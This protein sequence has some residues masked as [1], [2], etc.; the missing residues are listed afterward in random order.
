MYYECYEKMV[1]SKIAI[2]TAEENWLDKDGVVVEEEHLAFGR[3]TKYQ[4]ICPNY[5][6]FV[7]EVGDNTSQKDD[8]NIAGTKYVVGRKSRALMRA[9]HN[10]CH[11]TTL[12][13]S[14]A[15]GR[16]ILCVI[17]VACS[18]I[19]AKIRMGLQ[20][21]C[22]V[23]GEGAVMENLEANS[24]GAEKYFPFGPTCT[25]DGK[26]IPTF[27]GCSERGGITPEILRE[28]MAHIDSFNLFDREEATPVLLLDGHGSR[29]DQ[30]FLDYVN[31]PAT[32]WCVLIGVPYG[33]HLWQVADSSE[34][35]GSFKCEL[36]RAKQFVIKK[37]ESFTYQCR[38]KRLILLVLCTGHFK[39]HLLT[40]STVKKQLETE[41]GTP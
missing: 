8:G 19:D 15:D 17:I 3:K 32:K 25:I 40:L 28:A 37:K 11:F 9:A 4:M 12:G 10:D 34:Q 20:P 16:P 36:K 24:H 13:F 29:F 39:Y 31:A 18:E 7:D 23:E 27:M 41:V 35:N 5:L 1:E 38:W 21:W 14:L 33:T 6:V 30:Y 26:K 2:K 22:E